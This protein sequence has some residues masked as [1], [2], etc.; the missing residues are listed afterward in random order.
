MNRIAQFVGIQAIALVSVLSIPG[1]VPRKA[2][3]S[4]V[5]TDPAGSPVTHASVEALPRGDG[6]TGGTV[7]NRP[8]PWIQADS[9][10]TFSINLPPG[11]YKI[12]AKDEIDGYPDPV[13]LLNTDPTTR[14]PEISVE[15]QDV[16]GVRV[17]L[18]ARGGILDGTVQDALTHR[19]VA[20][21]KVTIQDARNPEAYV[22][23]FADKEGHVQFTVPSKPLRVSA[24]ANAYRAF[25]Y[26]GRREVTLSPGEHRSI[27]LELHSHE[28]DTE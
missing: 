3:V 5:V 25:V 20:Q 6:G 28:S 27:L 15:E 14:F 21:S 16:S 26:E 23:V 18:G 1:A 13:Y 24:T 4:G 7:G 8:N 11:R 9:R 12:R 22:E 17:V 10:G 19:P 2:V